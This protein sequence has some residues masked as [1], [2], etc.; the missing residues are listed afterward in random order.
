MKRALVAGL[1]AA[2]IAGT[3]W[4]QDAR[5]QAKQ[6]FSKG[7]ASYRLGNYEEAARHYEESYRLA[8][9]PIIL[10]NIGQAWRKSFEGSRTLEH[11]RRAVEVYRAYLRDDP[12]SQRRAEVEGLVKEIEDKVGGAEREAVQRSVAEATGE[13]ALRLAEEMLA[14]GMW[15]E[16]DAL[17]ESFLRQGA[18]SREHT[19]AAYRV[20]AYAAGA[21]GDAAR[22]RDF[23]S[24]LLALRPEFKVLEPGVAPA[25]L[26]AWEEARAYWTD[27]PRFAVSHVPRGALRPGERAVVEVRVDSDPLG[28][29]AGFEVRYRRA[30]TRAFSEARS[31]MPA[32]EIPA[33][34]VRT[35]PPGS[36]IDYY[37]IV[38]DR[39]GAPV[40]AL[41][42][43][44]QP[45]MF[46][47][48]G[49]AGGSAVAGVDGAAAPPGPPWHRRWWV[50]GAAGAVAVGATVAVLIATRPVEPERPG[51][52]ILVEGP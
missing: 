2:L 39:D 45:H 21:Q 23:M 27:K 41:G 9:I 14:R 1:V 19:A 13:G 34:F 15:K 51:D 40:A 25:T 22:A 46:A 18:R 29:C 30:G 11:G 42:A 16:A 8:P 3:A 47:V 7:E 43:E 48:L 6:A 26:A 49:G 20:R 44:E 38:R 50:W 33:A 28:L 4:A 10:F 36:S 12:K 37:V 32:T 52:A 17:A 5:E 24:R 35:L 31:D